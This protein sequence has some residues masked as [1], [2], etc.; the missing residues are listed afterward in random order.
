MKRL[1]LSIALI[2]TTA[3]TFAQ[4]IPK[5]ELRPNGFVSAADSTKNYVVLEVPKMKQAELYKK[6]LTY[7]NGLY[8][9]PSQVISA[10]DGESITVNGYTDAITTT[11]GLYKYPL[12]Y[13]LILKFKDGKIRFETRISELEERFNNE[14]SG[15][16]FYVANTDSPQKVEVRAIYMK[17]TK[18][19]GYYLINDELKFK[20]DY[21]VNNYLN[22]TIGSLTSNNDNW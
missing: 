9:N 19:T 20:L 22:N 18:N 2:I 3:A 7:L 1:I 16:P 15:H 12:K 5:M 4:S 8:K 21:W 11:K 6:T 17:S 10:V 13:N 14:N